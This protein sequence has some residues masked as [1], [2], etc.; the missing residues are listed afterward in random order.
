MGRCKAS[1]L[2]GETSILDF[3]GQLHITLFNNIYSI[4]EHVIKDVETN[5]HRHGENPIIGMQ[6]IKARWICVCHLINP[7]LRACEHGIWIEKHLKH[8]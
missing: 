8:V 3:Y 6:N 5:I 2:L 1:I 7:Y 4:Q